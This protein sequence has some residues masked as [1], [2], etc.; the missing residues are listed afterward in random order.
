VTVIDLRRE[1]RRRGARAA[2]VLVLMVMFCLA[3]MAAWFGRTQSG[4][5]GAPLLPGGMLP[6]AP[7]GSA[8]PSSAPP[9]TS[10]SSTPTSPSASHSTTRGATGSTPSPGAPPAGSNPS[11]PGAGSTAPFGPGLYV[12]G[13]DIAAGTWSTG[14]AI[15]LKLAPCTYRIN[16]GAPVSTSVGVGKTRVTLHS[17]QTF[18][19]NGCT[20]SWSS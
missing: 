10:P 11:S 5:D 2:L 16:G 6:L 19:T 18:E 20:W 17:G 4:V 3:G 13:V 8:Q 9:S 12:V 1:D 14:G 15:N 7:P